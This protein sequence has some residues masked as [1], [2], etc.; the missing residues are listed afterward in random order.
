M[1]KKMVIDASIARASSRADKVLEPD[2]TDYNILKGV[3]CRDF[4]DAFRT[5]KHLLVMTRE[6]Y[7]EWQKHQSNYAESWYATMLRQSQVF[8]CKPNPNPTLEN[9][10]L[11][12]EKDPNVQNAM[13]KD[14]LLIHGCLSADRYVAS[15][16]EKVRRYFS[17]AAQ[18][19]PELQAICWVDPTEH[20]DALAD[21]LKRDAPMNE[22]RK[23]GEPI[24]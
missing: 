7:A 20:I 23:L 5:T 4:L 3:R 1:P 14:L 9:D 19:V 16:E 13:Q 8:A 12:A 17:N 11:L 21:W 15:K 6:I 2:T 24:D 18:T 10:I 22:Q